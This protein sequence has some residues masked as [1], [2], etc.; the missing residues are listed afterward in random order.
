MGEI[1]LGTSGYSFPDWKGTV[2][3][4]GIKGTEMFSHY[5]NQFRFSTVEINYTYYRQPS[6][7]SMEMLA[8][9]SPADFDFTVKL[10][11]GIT[12]EPWKASTSPKPDPKLCAEYLEGLRP[13]LASGKLGCLLAEFPMNVRENPES[14]AYLLAL[15]DSLENLPLVYE[16][17]NR[18]WASKETLSR[19]R[20]EG[21]GFCAVDEPHISQLMPLMPEVTSDIAYLRLHGRSKNWFGDLASRYDYLYT[22]REL[23]DFLPAIGSMSEKS[24]VTYVMFNNCHMGS[25]VRNAKMLRELMGMD[26]PPLQ[27]ELF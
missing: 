27:G 9:K 20:E 1:R 26:I 14:W 4:S 3:P 8:V 24:K 16:F 6:A 18:D 17:R 7:K 5:V 13:L 23:R 25:S 10:F 15:R 11:G 22:E 12:H 19:L 2:Y 21:I